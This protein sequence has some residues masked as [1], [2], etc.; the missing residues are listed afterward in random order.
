MAADLYACLQAE[1]KPGER[2]LWHGYCQ[3][4]VGQQRKASDPW[5]GLVLGA[6]V[7]A[8]IG[9]II[10]AVT[11]GYGLPALLLSVPLGGYLGYTRIPLSSSY[12]KSRTVYALTDRRV[13]VLRDLPGGRHVRSVPLQ[14][15]TRIS[16]QPQS[17]IDGG[18]SQEAVGP[19]V[20]T[21][22]FSTARPQQQLANVP[23]L[24]FFMTIH[25]QMVATMTD[26]ARTI[27]LRLRASGASD[28]R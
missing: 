10:A 1:L 5:F 17:L 2:L 15:V 13:F 27:A 21:V 28:D 3:S 23:D 6:I 25:P 20:G 22:I 8:V 16:V 24:R 26:V 12:R 14:F 9:V 18:S 4:R 19:V 7:G 11:R